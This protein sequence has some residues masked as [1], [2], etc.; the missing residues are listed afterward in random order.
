M[1][2]PPDLLDGATIALQF[3]QI[4]ALELATVVRIL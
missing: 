1:G 2:V 3:A 4:N